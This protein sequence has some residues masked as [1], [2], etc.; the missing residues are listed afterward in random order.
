MINADPL[1]VTA[2][3]VQKLYNSRV[4]V[5]RDPLEQ[6][7]LFKDLRISG[8]RDDGYR[9]Y[10][11]L[12]ESQD[13]TEYK[14][15]EGVAK[16]E[17]A[18]GID[19]RGMVFV[20]VQ[21][22]PFEQ[23][24]DPRYVMRQAF[25]ARIGVVE[26]MPAME[27]VVEPPA[28]IVTRAFS[29]QERLD[30]GLQPASQLAENI[31]PP[32]SPPPI[33][34]MTVEVKDVPARHREALPPWSETVS[35]PSD[36][37]LRP[38][39]FPSDDALRHGIEE[40]RCER[41]VQSVIRRISETVL[42]TRVEKPKAWD[43]CVTMRLDWLILLIVLI[44]MSGWMIEFSQYF[45]SVVV[46]W[47]MQRPELVPETVRG[48]FNSLP[49]TE[50]KP[51][52]DHT[53]GEAAAD[54]SGASSFAD[55]LASTLGRTAYFFQMSRSD[56]RLGRVG[57]RSYYWVKDL[58]VKAKAHKQPDN[59]MAVMIDVDQYVDMPEWL[60]G[61]K[62]PTLLYTV[63][64]TRLSRI[65][66]N[67]S[68][69]FDEKDQ[70]QYIVS[71]GG[72]YTHK[73]WN[74]ST[75]HLMVTKSYCGIPYCLTAYCVDR[76][77]TSQDHELILLTPLGTWGFLMAWAV[78][79]LLYGKLLQRLK[80]V[81]PSGFLRLRTHGKDG[82][83]TCT[84]KPNQHAS[85]CID[86]E[87]DDTIAIL[88]R[89]SKY[90][91]MEPQVQSICKGDKA[92][93]AVLVEYHR[94]KSGK[95]FPPVVCPVPEGVRRYQYGTEY[96]P[97]AKASLTAFMCPIINGAFAPDQT[98]GNERQCIRGRIE[99]VRPPNLRMTPFLQ[100]VMHQFACRLVPKEMVGTLHPLNDDDVME[101]QNKPS[102]RRI[103]ENSRLLDPKRFV[104]M[105][106]KKEAYGKVTDPRPISQING[107][108]KIA[109]SKFTYA[110]ETLFKTQKWYAFGKSPLD[111][112]QR[113]A[114]VCA[115][116]EIA[117]NTDFSRFDG[118]GSN[119]MRELER[120]VLLRAF[121]PQYH[122]Q[123]IELHKSQYGLTGFGTYHTKYDTE[124]SRASGS[125]ETSLF[126]SMVN[127]F[128]A[129]LALRMTKRRG[130]FL[131]EQ[132]AY[133]SL[134]IYGG[135]DGLTADIEPSIYIR[136]AKSIGQELTTQVV[137]RGEL[138]VKFLARVYSPM[139]WYGCLDSCCDLKRQLS[140]FHVTVNM[141]PDIT[142]Q[143]KFLEKSR[144]VL[145][146]DRYTPIIG[147][148]CTRAENLAGRLGPNERVAAVRNWLSQFP[149]E[150][151]YPNEPGDWMV[152]YM[153]K[154]V[155]EVDYVGL[156]EW[157]QSRTSIEQIMGIAQIQPPE[158]PEV[159]TEVVLDGS[160]M[161]TKYPEPEP[162]ESVTG[163]GLMDLP[164]GK[165]S[166]RYVP[167]GKRPHRRPRVPPPT[168]PD[169]NGVV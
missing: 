84:G 153:I 106:M 61:M 138:G 166:L 137:R 78:W 127:A 50:S 124:F 146:S 22:R 122:S 162:P 101:R 82:V 77:A 71:G 62:C 118:H 4:V 44:G 34:T 35:F 43:W 99:Q 129:F 81:M 113:V 128:V 8:S 40:L 155:P 164:D 104:K 100:K 139:V 29:H 57:S 21:R 38:E 12:L 47:T 147:D 46:E 131:E 70:I 75:D 169:G 16:R 150:S 80:V 11:F 117:V 98:L 49:Y 161:E 132:E 105:F 85:A 30:R 126:N 60:C 20:V 72:R 88:S 32:P 103:I 69:T 51:M 13:L 37:A 42:R 33:V 152:E 91:L 65:T 116:A 119:L 55:R 74:Y 151:Q 23:M 102:Q 24:R 163:L 56:E 64:P 39:T 59:S 79:L 10:L 114:E 168:M 68:Y 144:C 73:I 130:V 45:K 109:Y 58:N 53:H 133:D 140:K 125:P 14:W 89:T 95:D 160:L 18:D 48:A 134:G 2:E 111:I 90:A 167:L 92:T 135:D 87:Q 94:T 86:T 6:D 26:C 96:E 107:P 121:S 52:A 28:N 76:R 142:P 154:A 148:I 158:M 5:W 110:C 108:D 159:K 93:S 15:L 1:S 19:F 83:K 7:L 141:P 9:K 120:I 66:D 123:L 36:N 63:Q 136:A 115:D 145:L 27:Y 112:A 143:E 97:E 149:A 25:L 67:Y 31:N 165:H 17:V 41:R 156:T 157:L 3:Q 54:R